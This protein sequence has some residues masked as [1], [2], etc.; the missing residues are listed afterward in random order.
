MQ[1]H[2]YKH[3]NVYKHATREFCSGEVRIFAHI[4]VHMYPYRRW[5]FS[6]VG[7]WSVALFSAAERADLGIG[8]LCCSA[9]Q[10]AVVC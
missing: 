9:L 3:E 10:C 4:Y 5:E 8:T 2:L 6:M 7:L 1:I